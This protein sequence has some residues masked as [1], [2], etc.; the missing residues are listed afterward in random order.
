MNEARSCAECIHEF[1]CRVQNGGNY[2]ANGTGAKCPAYESVRMSAAYHIGWQDG[3]RA[4]V[5]VDDAKEALDV[6]TK[7][8]NAQIEEDNF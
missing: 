7:Y 2:M 4:A 6:L 8:I 3:R 1:R 5:R